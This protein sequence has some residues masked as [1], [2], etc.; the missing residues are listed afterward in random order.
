[1][2]VRGPCSW[3]S[4]GFEVEGPFAW[5]GHQGQTESLLPR[6]VEVTKWGKL[7]YEKAERSHDAPVKLVVEHL[8]EEFRRGI[9]R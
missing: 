5:E 7:D 3:H 2:L 8:V 4:H 9:A 6:Q 1:M